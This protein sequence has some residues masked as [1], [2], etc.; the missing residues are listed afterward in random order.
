MH[1]NA[2]SIPRRYQELQ[3]FILTH[4]CDICAISETWIKLNHPI[5]NYNIPGYQLINHPRQNNKQGGGVCFYIR[6]N[7]PTEITY[8]THPPQIPTS[9]SLLCTVQCMY[10]G[11]KLFCGCIY[12]APQL[13]PLHTYTDFCTIIARLK[14]EHLILGGD[15]NTDIATTTYS[16]IHKNLLLMFCAKYSLHLI[17][18]GCTHKTQSLD[19]FIVSCY[20]A[21]TMQSSLSGIADHDSIFIEV[22]MTSLKTSVVCKHIN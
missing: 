7:I 16:Q 17:S 14:G 3:Q 18:F 19:Y 1:M 22:N 10:E 15:F 11:K 13:P 9:I 2:Y 12:K 21:I 8:T 6:D 4:N 20:D 5:A